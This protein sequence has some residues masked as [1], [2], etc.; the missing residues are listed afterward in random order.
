MI[1][2]SHSVRHWTLGVLSALSLAILPQ[3][4][5]QAQAADKVKLVI[6][7]Q[8]EAYPWL[9]EASGVLKDTPYEVQWAVLPGPAAQLSGLY[10][11]SLDIGLLG[12]ASLILEQGK[13]KTPW[14]AENAPLRIIAGWRNHDLAYPP[15][16]TV[17]QT[18]TG[19][20]KVQDLRGK[21]W[22]YNY[23]GL[24]HLQYLL[25]LIE[26][27]LKPEDIEPVQLGDGN[28]SASAFNAGRVDAYSGD[29]GRV[30]ESLDRGS[31]KILLTSEHFD[32]PAAMVFAARGDVLKDAAK[33]AALQDFL[34]RFDKY[35][36]WYAANL[37]TV[38]QIY[39]SKVKQ[40]PVQARYST[41]QGKARLIALDDALIARE[42]KV[43]DAFH[44]AGVIAQKV[45]V[46][47]EFDR[48]FRVPS[49]Q[50]PA[51]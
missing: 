13:A 34:V 50:Q 32:I 14:T 51:N 40:T 35:W 39:I 28:A 38:E 1:D 43:A 9:V 33:H 3:Q 44:Q 19:I 30:R 27:G 36:S 15:M 31:A 37:D 49:L 12:D 46:S 47:I 2:L 18:S 17:V 21:K 7:T 23:G 4:P 26:A 42:Q 16:V 10:S 41:L 11:K 22:A 45:D 24:N 48:S 6:G 20:E 29:T 5:A 8:Y 25:S